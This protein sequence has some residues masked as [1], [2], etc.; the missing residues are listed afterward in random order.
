VTLG[1]DEWYQ[2]TSFTPTNLVSIAVAPASSFLMPGQTQ[3]FVSTGTFNDGSTQTLQS[4]I[5]SSSNPSAAIISN[6]TGSAG[7]VNAQAQGATTLTATAGDVGGSASLN[8]AGLVSLTI[9]PSNPSIAIGSGQQFTATGT[10]SDGSQQ[11]VTA[12][13]TWSSSNSS[14]VL[15]G[16]GSLGLQGYAAGAASG[17]ATITG[18][19]GSVSAS[20]S[21]TVQSSTTTTTPNI[22][23]VSPSTATGGMQVTISGTGFGPTPGSGTVWLGTTYATVV[24]WTNTQIVA[25]VAAISQSGTAQVQQNGLSS[26]PVQFNVNTA[27]ISNVSPVSGVPGTK[28]TITGSGF[29]AAQGQVF[30]GTAYGVVQSWS[31][32]Q[33]VALVASGS[34][35]GWAQILQGGV[36]SNSVSFAVNSLQI[37]SVT[38]TSGGPGTSV[39]I[40][41]NGFGLN[42]GGGQVWLGGANGGVTSW[43]NTQVVAVV[44]AS[45]LTGVVR[46]EQNGVLSNAISFTVPTSG[47]NSLTLVPNM[48]NLVIGQTQTIQALNPSSQ[49]VTGLTWTSSNPN[50]VSLSTD[51]P[52]ILTALTAGHV[53]ITAGSASA[54]VTVYTATLPTGTVIWSNPGDGSGV[55]S[56]VPAVP[57]ATGVA[58]VF[59]FQSDGTVQAITSSGAT[60]W[61]ANLNG[62]NYWQSV[63]DFQ[64]GLVVANLANQTHQSI[65]K[66]DGITGQAYPAYTPTTQNDSLSMPVVHTDGTIFT[67]DTNSSA[68]TVSVIGVNPTTGAQ[69]FS[70]PLDQSTVSYTQTRVANAYDFDCDEDFPGAYDESYTSYTT[71]SAPTLSGTPMIAGDGHFYV[72]YEYQNETQVSQ[73]T[74]VCS[75]ITG[76][77]ESDSGTTNTAAHLVLMRV[78]T[79]GSSSK[80]DVKDWESSGLTLLSGGAAF[81][82]VNT[83]TAT[84]AVPN[85]RNIQTL[86]N[87]DTGAVLSWEAD[88]PTYC[89]SGTYGF[90]DCNTQVAAASAYGFATTVDTNVAYSGSTSAPV[91]PV[92]QAQDGTFYGTDNTY[93]NMIHFSQSGNVI[94][95]V[96][97]DYPQ[98][99]TADGGVIG[100]SGITYDNQGRANGQIA[101][102][103]YA[104]TG[105]AYQN[106]PGR[107]QQLASTPPDVATSFWPGGNAQS[108]PGAN[109]S[110][111]STAYQ[112]IVETLYVRS[113]APWQWFGI[114]PPPYACADNCFHGD[115][116]S[117]TT[118]LSVTSRIS[119]KIQ[120]RLPGMTIYGTPT[121]T[122][123]PSVD[124]YGRTKTAVD[125]ITTTSQG[126]M[127]NMHFSGANPLIWP[128]SLSPDIDTRLDLIGSV[129]AAPDGQVCYYGNLYGDQFPDAEVFVVNSQ[130]QATTLLTFTTPGGP[131]SGPIKYLPGDGID[132]MGTF[133][134]VCAAK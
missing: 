75:V 122:S 38:P 25:T 7:I 131:N 121:A 39:T 118:S 66:L 84:G 21:V 56:I 72:A 77:S 16:T 101:M 20:T 117:F 79:D 9:S 116:R 124:V 97:N 107:A 133:S 42:Q 115:D 58:D 87:A 94:W 112:S 83:T 99:A 80:I 52:P 123:S 49:P 130:N 88:T 45:A 14:T 98:I 5:W 8:V 2:P 95:S 129:D 51:D 106:D 24:S 82:S 103:V 86:T 76:P 40:T 92:L 53:T 126:G 78:G 61:T 100:T 13:V 57:S 11:N 27:T 6:S 70:V 109:A 22:L 19:L 43:S 35:S 111:T 134:R 102:P 90:E 65:S 48:L 18:T 108:P 64:G 41:G 96:P 28:V 89:A 62:A 113:F 55:I 93:S 119:G 132:N 10:F 47:G 127:L 104:W 23:T 81:P 128:Q 91:S 34:M 73:S 67:V 125:T 37:T 120:F 29:G 1:S 74:L 3:Q 50:V 60:A 46:I 17:T 110:G 54:D 33:V 85:L 4:V 69:L 63:P 32:T 68:N 105:D 31:D 26:N 15:I 30:L 36:W 71:S 44:A 114:E 12:P 59:A